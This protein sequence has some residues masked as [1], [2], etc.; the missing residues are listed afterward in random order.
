MMHT[1]DNKL[2]VHYDLLREMQTLCAIE[3][4]WGH[5]QVWTHMLKAGF[6]ECM[7]PACQVLEWA[8]S[9]KYLLWLQCS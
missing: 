9:R 8:G 7:R 5:D 4:I 6:P 2:G 3:E 1:L